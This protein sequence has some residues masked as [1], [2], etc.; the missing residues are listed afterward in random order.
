MYSTHKP[1]PEGFNIAID[2]FNCNKEE[3]LYVGR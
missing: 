3:V 1:D 2:Y